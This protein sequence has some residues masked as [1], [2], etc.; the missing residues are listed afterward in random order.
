MDR[1]DFIGGRVITVFAVTADGS[2][3]YAKVVRSPSD[4]MSNEVMRV[5]KKWP[6]FSRFKP[7]IQYALPVGFQL[8]SEDPSTPV[9]EIK[10]RI[11]V[12]S[13]IYNPN[14]VDIP[15]NPPG[16]LMLNEVILRGY[17]KK[18]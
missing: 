1:H 2:L 15:D 16:S 12:S 3:Q 11:N 8:G 14:A 10:T 9:P 5:L 13:N 6:L 7:G 18:Q 17:I 4:L